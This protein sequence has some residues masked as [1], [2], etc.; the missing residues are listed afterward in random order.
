MIRSAGLLVWRREETVQV[1]LGHPGGP[2]FVRKDDGV[3]S[4]PKGEHD[5]GE[6]ALVAAYREF[7]EEI[8]MPPPAGEPLPL[9]E[10]TQRSGKIVTAWA[11]QGDLDATAMRSNLFTMQWPP[12]SGREQQFPELDRAEWFDLPTAR[13]KVFGYQQPFLDRLLAAVG[14]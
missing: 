6:P 8:G 9:G 7:T 13:R 2:L 3:W 11:L 12:R 4:I 14:D 10:V 5:P 1:L